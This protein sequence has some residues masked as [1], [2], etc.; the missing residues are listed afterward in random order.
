MEFSDLF[1]FRAIERVADVLIGA[2]SIYLGYRLFDKLPSNT[3]SKGKII[4]P[5]GISIYLSRV[6]PGVFFALFGAM[7]VGS[8][9]VTGLNYEERT[10]GD[11]RKFQFS[12]ESPEKVGEESFAVERSVLIADVRKLNQLEN[13]LNNYLDDNALALSQE[14]VTDLQL[15]IPRVK[16]V[17]FKHVWN[18]EWGDYAEFKKWATDRNWESPPD[19]IKVAGQLFTQK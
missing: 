10:G 4:L 15:A 12:N 13:A 1:W 19:E 18:E 8:S 6:G 9:V 16:I 11:V 3:D 7:I 5:G 17:V 14:L 2:I